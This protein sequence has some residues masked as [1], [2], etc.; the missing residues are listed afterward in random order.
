MRSLSVFAFLVA[1]A[2]AVPALGQGHSLLLSTSGDAATASGAF[3]DVDDEEILVLESS[4]ASEPAEFLS[5]FAWEVV[6]GDRDG[7][8]AFDDEPGELDALH[9]AHD[10]ASRPLLFDA[11]VSF[12]ATETLLGGLG[13]LDGDLV[14]IGPGGTGEIVIDEATFEV[15]TG[16]SNVDVDAFV[17][18]A[19]GDTYFSFADTEETT[20]EVLI[21]ENGGDPAM[22]D[23]TVFVKRTGETFAHIFLTEDQVLQLVRNALQSEN[24]SIGDTQGLAVDPMHPGEIFFAVSSTASGIEGT[25]FSTHDGGSVAMLDGRALAGSELGFATEEALDALSVVPFTKSPIQVQMDSADVP[26]GDAS[27][28]ELRILGGTPG[29]RVRVLASPAVLPVLAPL[30][31]DTLTGVGHF[32]VDTTSNLFRNSLVRPKF[33][34]TLDERGTGVYRHPSRPIPAGIQR[35]VQVVDV[36]T[37]EISEGV[38]IEVVEP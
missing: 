16:T 26:A 25:V 22:L 27:A 6:L 24:R 33:E 37:R 14:R 23:G 31:D 34:L 18:D 30:P 4:A 10:L 8:G 1:V 35:L 28:I 21:Q 19:T 13:V 5:D 2:G 3:P 7:D 17:I 32:Y 15:W 38:A 29:G 9:L 36:T 12:S 11:L 20:Y